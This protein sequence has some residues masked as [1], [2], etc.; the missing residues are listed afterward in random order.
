MAKVYLSLGT[1]IGDRLENLR[2]AVNLLTEKVDIGKVSSVYETEPWGFEEQDRFLNIALSG[3]TDLNPI[4]LLDFTQSI[5][6]AM[7][8]VKTV[9][10]GPRVID[11][12]ILLYEGVE[13]DTERL[14]IPH[15]RIMERAFV[16]VPLKEI[17][18]DDAIPG[19]SI[20]G[21]LEKIGSEGVICFREA[22]WRG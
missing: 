12:D 18:G 4:E 7:K 21:L 6:G 5:E 3:E 8:R 16:L 13:M 15:A 10:Y 11:V 19:Q 1:N 17:A 14:T 22:P 9:R 2:E 20:S